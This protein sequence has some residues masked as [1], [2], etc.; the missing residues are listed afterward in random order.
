M[1]HGVEQLEQQ[2]N[3]DLQQNFLNLNYLLFPTSVKL[4]KAF[5]DYNRVDIVVHVG[6]CIK[7][8]GGR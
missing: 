1:E 7:I 6:N 5:I 4:Y 2:K 8:K 3:S